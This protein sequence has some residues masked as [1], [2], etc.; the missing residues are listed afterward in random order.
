[1]EVVN[2]HLFV[3]VVR[4]SRIFCTLPVVRSKV[5]K[6]HASI[7]NET[8]SGGTLDFNRM[9]TTKKGSHSLRGQL[10]ISF[11]HLLIFLNN[12][13]FFIINVWEMQYDIQT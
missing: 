2:Q 13:F 4:R 3:F 11:M 5:Y 1:M 6:Y 10:M 9:Q 12:I 7:V 8:R